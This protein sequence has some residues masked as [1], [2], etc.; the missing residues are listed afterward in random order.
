M[1]HYS[2]DGVLLLQTQNVQEFFLDLDHSIK[3]TPAFH[4][5]LT[6]SQVHKGDILIARS[7]LFGSAAI[8]LE[9]ELVNSAD[10]IIVEVGDPRIDS[11]YAVTFMN[12]RHG[13]AQL[14][15]FASGGV[16]GHV[17]LRILEQFRIPVFGSDE[18]GLVAKY[19]HDAY[20]TR[21]NS[22]EAYNAATHLLET[23]LGLDNLTFQKPVGY[24]T[25]LSAIEESRRFDS[26]HYFPAFQ[27]F[28][29]GLPDGVS[30]S[31]LSNYLEFCQRGKQPIYS[32]K[33]L[34]VI[35]SKHVQP[36]RVICDGNRLAHA[37][38]D[39]NLQIRFGDTLLNGTGR[40]TIGRAAPY[41]NKAMAVA[42]N[43]VTVL[44]S[45]KLDPAYLALY[46]NSRAGLMQV[47]MHQ[48]GS[49]GQLELY[50]F[51]IRKFLVWN[52]PPEVQREIRRLHDL[53]AAAEYES[54]MLLEQAKARV[55]QLIKE[56]YAA[57]NL[58]TED[59]RLLEELCEQHGVSREK[60]LKLLDAVREYEFKDRRTGVYDALREIL[61]SK[62]AQHTERPA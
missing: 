57:M 43:H 29:T 6:K 51:D 18:Q 2:D 12:T 54:H 34:P 36:N 16:Q 55:E 20:Q 27:A 13:S 49:S 62:P 5:S 31:P 24:T 38:P 59:T 9:D 35:N 14:V 39:A 40:G 1:S 23:K 44:R 8:Y 45:T 30:L 28:K 19:V 52:A 50:P 15:R 11:L 4:A 21:R 17:N 10:I 42:D 58:S 32:T 25:C 7:G 37:S 33:G 60:V 47:E 56:A 22:A 46:L 3:V 48:R 41:L 53:G 26:E 61:K